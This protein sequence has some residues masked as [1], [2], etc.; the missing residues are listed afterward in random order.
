MKQL[1]VSICFLLFSFIT[2]GQEKEGWIYVGKATDGTLYYLKSEVV[3]TNKIWTMTI[4]PNWSYKKVPYKNVT[5]KELIQFDCG[6]KQM[7][8]Y[9]FVYYSSKGNLILS[10]QYEEYE[11][12]WQNSIPESMGE[13]II[14]KICELFNN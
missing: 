3:S 2:Y 11:T 4:L 14:N 1:F 13:V 7:K 9:Q 10:E 6:D 12:M 8:T 5:V